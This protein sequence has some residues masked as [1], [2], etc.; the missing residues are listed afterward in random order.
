M[1]ETH[2]CDTI[3]TSLG[4]G[5]GAVTVCATCFFFFDKN[6]FLLSVANDRSSSSANLFTFLLMVRLIRW[7]S[8]YLCFFDGIGHATQKS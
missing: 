8:S 1:T 7:P 3:L 5:L 4:F 6:V 2:F